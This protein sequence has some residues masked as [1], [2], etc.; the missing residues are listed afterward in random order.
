MKYVLDDFNYPIDQD[1]IAQMPLADKTQAKLLVVNPDLSFCHSHIYDLGSII[2]NDSLI[3]VNDS[4]VIHSRIYAHLPTGG[5]IEIF[6]LE[7]KTEDDSSDS[8]YCEWI[9]LAKPA[10]KLKE[11]QCIPLDDEVTASIISKKQS[12]NQNELSTFIVRFNLDFSSFKSWLERNGRVP[13]PP[14]ISRK[15]SDTKIDEIDKVSYQTVYAKHDGSVAAPTA[16]L[17]F[18]KELITHLKSL[19]IQFSSISL[20][21]GAGTFLPVTTDDIDQHT[22]HSERYIVPQKTIELLYDFKKR[23]RPI[24]FV[25]TTTLR[26]LESFRLK[27]QDSWDLM[28]KESDSIQRTNLFI[29]P[30][31]PSYRYHPFFNTAL[32][33]NFHQPRSTLLML[34]ASLIGLDNIKSLYQEAIQ[35]NYRFFSYGDACLFWL[36]K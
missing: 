27:C 20:H 2:P 32:I 7:P 29:R 1:Q 36:K 34:V 9:A 14:Y 35:K 26:C 16:G 15:D 8:N 24:I 17:H 13:L 18:S 10:R 6:L 28:L 25:G 33:T 31:N 21:V 23:Q 4:R 30:N 22:M 12:L 3:V 19:D 11:D 5:K